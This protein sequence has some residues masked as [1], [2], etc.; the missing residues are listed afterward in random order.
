MKKKLILRFVLAYVL[1]TVCILVLPG[2][3]WFLMK[4][5]GVLW[6]DASRSLGG[7]LREFMV[8]GGQSL[9][10]LLLPGWSVS[11]LAGLLVSAGVLAAGAELFARGPVKDYRTLCEKAD[12]LAAGAAAAGTGEKAGLEMERKLE[13]IAARLAD[14]QSALRT[15][16][17]CCEEAAMLL[18]AAC[19]QIEVLAEAGSLAE[20]SAEA[21]LVQ[22]AVSKIRKANSKIVSI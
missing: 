16:R 20:G 11:S 1:I 15:Q 2:S 17:T 12:A 4:G 6:Q 18:D 8:Y 5:L 7:V 21:A 13:A 14:A 3:V 9:S 19:T 22:D 10:S